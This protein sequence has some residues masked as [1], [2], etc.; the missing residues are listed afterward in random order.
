M[1]SGSVQG[2]EK[3]AMQSLNDRLANFMNK[4][5]MLEKTNQE[6]EL[7]IKEMVKGKGSQDA[8]YESYYGII[9]DLRA[10]VCIFDPLLLAW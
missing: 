8:D 10:K 2:N 1:S 5:A 7:K 4:V 6:L 3:Q 9:A